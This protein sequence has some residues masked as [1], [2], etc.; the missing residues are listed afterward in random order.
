MNVKVE[1]DL[2]NYVTKVNV[3]EAIDIDTSMRVLKKDLASLTTKVNDLDVNKLK[4][5]FV[6]LSKISS[7]V[8][9]DVVKKNAYDEL[10]TKVS[11]IDTK[12]PNITGLFTVTQYN[13]EK[14]GLEK[15]IEEVDKKYP[16][17]V[18]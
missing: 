1:L 11:A 9:N 10:V 5:F 14:N 13:S 7:L 16:I 4:T 3:K 17:L 8:D 15:K 18:G 6:N 12:I 2:S